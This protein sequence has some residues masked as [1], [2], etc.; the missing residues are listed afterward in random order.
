MAWRVS[1]AL[2]WNRSAIQLHY[3]QFLT[4][5]RLPASITG[6]QYRLSVKRLRTTQRFS[7]I[8]RHVR[9]VLC[10]TVN[11]RHS[12]KSRLILVT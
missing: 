11:S 2:P 5:R 12:S 1:E 9:R 3:S 8:R 10:F 4:H 6:P 7:S